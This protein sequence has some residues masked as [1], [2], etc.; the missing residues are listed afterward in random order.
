MRVFVLT[1]LVENIILLCMILSIISRSSSKSIL[2]R[3][4]WSG[5]QR[6]IDDHVPCLVYV[7][8]ADRKG[9]EK[10]RSREVR[11]VRMDT[12][13]RSDKLVVFGA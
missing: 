7:P 9:G 4:K 13:S 11:C 5:A 6:F 12:S 2:H 8:Y 10:M 3:S 1:F